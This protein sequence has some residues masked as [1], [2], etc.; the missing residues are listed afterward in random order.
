MPITDK[1]EWKSRIVT[2]EKI[3]SRIKPGMSIFLG[4]GVAEPR[5]L[6]K[7]L[8]A[9]DAGNLRD[10][11]FIQLMSFGQAV[12]IAEKDTQKFRLKTFFPGWVASEAITA[13][14]VDLESVFCGKVCL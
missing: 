2:P 4:T 13:G 1:K 9:S 7:S 11:E 14:S 6:I 5:T 3:L 10:L 8:M 12:S